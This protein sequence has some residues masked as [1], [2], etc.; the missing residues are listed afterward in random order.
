MREVE[1]FHLSSSV[2][3]MI[4]ILNLISTIRTEQLFECVG[5]DRL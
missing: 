5:D 1:L 2:Q 3:T 4:I